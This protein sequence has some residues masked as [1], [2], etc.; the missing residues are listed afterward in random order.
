MEEKK[1][2]YTCPMHQEIVS[3]KPGSCP[4]CG[5]NLVPE[6]EESKEE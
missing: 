6:E 4:K 1:Q 2:K 3:D 5:M